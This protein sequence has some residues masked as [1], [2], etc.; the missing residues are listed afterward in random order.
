MKIVVDR[1]LCEG[2]GMCESM[3]HEYFE[4]DDD[5]VMHVLNEN[6]PEEDRKMITAAVNS[7]PVLALKIE[8]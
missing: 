4:V 8:G 7:C 2:L 3:A 6:P 5:D 1:D